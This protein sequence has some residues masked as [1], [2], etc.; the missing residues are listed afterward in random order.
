MKTSRVACV[1][2][3]ALVCAAVIAGP[4]TRFGTAWTSG[5]SH[6]LTVGDELEI[7]GAEAYGVIL[8]TE[9]NGVPS[10]ENTATN[11][12]IYVEREFY[13]GMSNLVGTI[14]AG[15]PVADTKSES[16]LTNDT[17]RG[18]GDWFPTAGERWYVLP[19]DTLYFVGPTQATVRV[20]G[21]AR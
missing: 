8:G 4:Y 7:V 10:V 9:T 18:C 17:V 16:N 13:A 2:F 21:I 11:I 14:T 5:E 1:V 20:H 3:L 19:T 12:A 6:T 15:G